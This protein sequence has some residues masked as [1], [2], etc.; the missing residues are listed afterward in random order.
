MNVLSRPFTSQL[1][2]QG[3]LGGE[4][5]DHLS[6][7]H[8]LAQACSNKESA[9]LACYIGSGSSS[10]VKGVYIYAMQRCL[11]FDMFG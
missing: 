3:R 10:R 4:K 11:L 8:L 7:N 6:F 9:F 5:V 1:T 2:G